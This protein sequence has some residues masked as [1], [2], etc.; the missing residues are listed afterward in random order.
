MRCVSVLLFA[1]LTA[2]DAQRV[3]RLYYDTADEGRGRSAVLGALTLYLD[4]LNLFLL[5]LRFTGQ[6]RR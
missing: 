3:Q 6:R 5:L 4:F 1:G 2:F